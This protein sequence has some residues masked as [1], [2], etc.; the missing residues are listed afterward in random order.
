M[1]KGL[2]TEVQRFSVHD[3]PGIRTNVFFKGCPL[4]CPWCSNP[5]TQSSKP[6]LMYSQNRCMKCGMCQNVCI[7][8]CIAVKEDNFLYDEEK[9]I[10]CRK[11][12]DIC[13]V[14][15]IRFY[16]KEITEE[17]LLKE[18]KKDIPFFQKS[19]GGVTFSGGEPFMQSK[20]LL[21]TASSCKA[22]NINVAIETSGY[23]SWEAMEPLIDYTDYFLYDLKILDSIK[24]EK[25]T[26]QSNGRIIDNLKKLRERTKNVIIRIPII[27]G[28]T[29]SEENIKGIGKLAND[30]NIMEV[31]ILPYHNYAVSKYKQLRRTYELSDQKALH[32]EDVAPVSKMLSKMDLSV[33]IGG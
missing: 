30:L 28:Y 15:A 27:P 6:V 23:T 10:Q 8:E 5:E 20:F 2:I 32:D 25:I 7:K 24:H 1:G 31:H 11:C 18:I 13:P 16:G 33:K 21:D 17:D 14:T 19:G 26:G 3:G 9:C 12:E 22:Q 29:D 4:R